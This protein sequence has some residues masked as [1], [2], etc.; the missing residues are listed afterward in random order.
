[1]PFTF[2][3]LVVFIVTTLVLFSILRSRKKQ[4][5]ELRHSR[6]SSEDV[7]TDVAGRGHHFSQHETTVGGDIRALEK[8]IVPFRIA[9]YASL[10]LAV[11][12]LV[13]SVFTIVGTKQ[14]GVVTS[15]G[16]PVGT[17]SNGLHMKFPW[18]KVTELDGAIQTDNHFGD[19][20]T[21][22]RLGNQSTADVDNTVRWRIKPGKAD[23]LYRDYRDFDKIRDSLVTRELK[24]AL[25]EVF[26]DYDP[27]GTIK[28]TAEKQPTLDEL[29]ESVTTRLRSR[30]GSQID[31]Q[32][33]II[34]LTNFDK[35]TQGRINAY[36]AEIANT[37]IANQ[38][39]QTATAEAE[40]NRRLSNSVSK[41][42]N[43]LVSKCLDTLADL[44]KKGT[45]LPAGFS[46]WP[47]NGSVAVAVK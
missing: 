2:V 7:G 1:M 29:G 4:M 21:K 32:N 8:E 36:Q 23:E 45:A 24:A 47:G 39:Q 26:K 20:A 44:A 18:Q 37:R 34:P 27:L 46:C 12:F 13:F 14:V 41:D 22:I 11:L 15:F 28:G 3:L 42:P 10:T 19:G 30:V 40:A 38:R 5:S 43:V 16:Q 6:N 17:M 31:V 35:D 33:I 9:T 25:N